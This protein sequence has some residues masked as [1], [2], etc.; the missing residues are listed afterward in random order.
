MRRFLIK[1]A[2]FAVVI[3]GFAWGLDYIISMGTTKISGYPHQLWTEM[4]NHTFDCDGVIMGTSRGLEHYNPYILDSLTGHSFYNLGMGGYPIDKQLMKYRF[5][6]NYNPKP[7]YVI[8]D[9]DYITMT[10]PKSLVHDFQSE[11]Y[12]PLIYD[13]CMRQELRDM[14]YSIWDVY[15]PLVRWFGYQ[16]H[17][18]R[19]VFDYFNIQHHTE[20]KS[21]K[22]FSPDP[23]SWNPNNLRS[24]DSIPGIID[25]SQKVLLETALREWKTDSVYVIMVNSPKYY[26]YSAMNQ[27]RQ[28][29]IRYFDSLS[30]HFDIPYFDYCSHS[31]MCL[32]STL[33]NNGYHLTPVGAD[34]FSAEVA[35]NIVLEK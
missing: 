7:K 18:K 35:R 5:Y 31:W 8:L 11:Q 22:G 3:Y 27:N 13:K 15:F 25:E 19:G 16:T 33:F 26:A 20:Y 24:K 4:R 29:E 14:G 10:A 17:I 2:I 6:C 1:I 34:I 28:E 23:G 9:V 21:Y 32:D 30:I 12:L